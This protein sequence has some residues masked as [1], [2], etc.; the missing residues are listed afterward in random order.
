MKKIQSMFKN[1]GKNIIVSLMFIGIFL[2]FN[3]DDILKVI[4]GIVSIC[5]L[6]IAYSYNNGAKN[7]R[8]QQLLQIKKENYIKFLEAFLNKKIYFTKDTIIPIKK[9]GRFDLS[10]E[11][12]EINEIYCKEVCK[13][14]MYSSDY[15][16]E[17]IS[18][19]ILF[20]N[21]KISLLK[22]HEINI[23]VDDFKIP[24]DK[25][26]KY[27]EISFRRIRFKI[28]N[29]SNLIIKLEN[30]SNLKEAL[31]N[32]REENLSNETY[33]III[34][35]IL[36]DRTLLSLIRCDLKI[37]KN[38]SLVNVIVYPNFVNIDG[39]VKYIE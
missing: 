26:D 1:I 2:N 11:V 21:L 29:S 5:G 28:L 13:L 23:F 18:C 16:L 25:I 31:N 6:I 22:K 33:N 38:S 3:L 27:D 39:Q 36:S 7:Q 19:F 30:F 20:E 14:N 10:K 35:E 32:L 12:I 24:F 34:N 8:E 17:F 4:T 15:I 37:T 9:D